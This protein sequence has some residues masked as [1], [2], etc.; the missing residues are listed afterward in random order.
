MHNAIKS[1]KLISVRR[2]VDDAILTS[3]AP[4]ACQHADIP[5][6]ELACPPR[7]VRILEEDKARAMS[8][9]HCEK[10]GDKDN[11][12]ADVGDAGDEL[13][14]RNKPKSIHIQQAREH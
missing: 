14:P 2:A 13:D 3:E 8:R 12:E 1:F 5:T 9:S 7:G 11:E 6:G 4:S 10:N